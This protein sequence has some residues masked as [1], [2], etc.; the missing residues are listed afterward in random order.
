MLVVDCSVIGPDPVLNVTVAV[1]WI[2]VPAGVPVAR[3]GV[4]NANPVATAQTA[5]MMRNNFIPHAYK[6]AWLKRR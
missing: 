5:H 4:P 1:F 2:S 6:C 3:T